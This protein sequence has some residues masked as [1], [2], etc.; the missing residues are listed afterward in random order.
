MYFAQE[1]LIFHPEKM[2]EKEKIDFDIPMAEM[3]LKSYDG[4]K[5]SAVFCSPRKV[6]SNKIIFFLHGNAGNLHDQKQAAK[7]YTDLGYNFF[8]FDYRGFGKSE[9]NIISEDQFFKDIEAMYKEVRSLYRESSITVIGY[10]V[11]TASA[12]MIASKMK[13]S[14]LVLIAPYYSLV[15]MTRRRYPYIPTAL[16]KYRFETHEFLKKVKAPVLIAHGRE[17]SV[18][19]FESSKMM[20]GIIKGKGTFIPFSG[21]GHDDFE[22]N[23]KFVNVIRAFLS[24]PVSE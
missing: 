11:G 18:L 12:A 4:T 3:Q 6:L 17:D 23:E 21:Q 14:K 9:G 20:A 24:K 10:S 5:L 2:A 19:P 8:T 1:S 7:F 16:L 15:D 13:P 22:R